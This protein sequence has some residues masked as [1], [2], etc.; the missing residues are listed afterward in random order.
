MLNENN[1]NN[2][3]NMSNLSKFN[4]LNEKTKKLKYI[5]ITKCAGT[6]IENT[7]L[8]KNIKWGRFDT[9][10]KENIDE[11]WW[12]FPFYY[13]SF[14]LKNNYNWFVVV[15]N[16]YDRIISEFY[17]KF[18][19]ARIK[20]KKIYDIDYIKSDYQFNHFIR[21]IINYKNKNNLEWH[22][23]KQYLYLSNDCNIHILKFENLNND[24]N[25]LMKK[26]NIDLK[27]D[28]IHNKYNGEKK[29]T[30]KSF[31]RDTLNLINSFYHYDFL[32][33]NYNKM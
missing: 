29:F 13:K 15:R 21:K 6:T 14:K 30:I 16:P 11:T 33:F 23:E 26:Y 19:R 12:H 22:Y 2:N 24:F 9:D 1:N 32:Y 8:E 4:K 31:D 25:K 28:K 17:C 20:N 27:L 5:H 18:S 3:S 7:A 10:Y